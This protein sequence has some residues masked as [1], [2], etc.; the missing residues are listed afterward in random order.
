M[1]LGRHEQNQDRAQKE[2]ETRPEFY[3][4][5]PGVAGFLFPADAMPY[6]MCSYSRGGLLRYIPC[7]H[8]S[9]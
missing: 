3:L 4:T 8:F 7:K 1:L 6:A 2:D 5:P 9:R